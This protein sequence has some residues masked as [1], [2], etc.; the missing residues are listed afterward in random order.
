M[1]IAMPIAIDLLPTARALWRRK[2]GAALIAAQVALTLA[3]LCNALVVVLDRLGQTSRP[4]GVAED[5]LFYLQVVTPGYQDDPFGIQ[6][7]AEVLLRGLP[8]VNDA[9]WVNQVPL[10]NSGS[11]SGVSNE[12]LS[13]SGVNAAHYS[14]GRSL[15][16]AFGLKLVEGRDFLPDEFV[17]LDLRST[18]QPPPQVIVTRA[19]AQALYPGQ[20]S[21]V[22]RSVRLGT[23]TEDPLLTIVGVVER[24]VSPWGRASWMKGDTYG[25]RGF[26]TPARVNEGETYLV[27]ADPAGLDAI[28]QEA[29]RRLLDAVPGRILLSSRDQNTVRERRYRGDRW[30]AGMLGTVT[31][32]LLLMTA[33]GIVGLASLWVTQRRKQIGVRRALG[34]RRADIVGQFLVENLMINGAGVAL[35]LTLAVALNVGLARVTA[36]PPLPAGLMAAGALAL[37]VLGA[38]SVLAPAV[39]AS[40]ISPAEATRSA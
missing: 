29:E 7:A 3:I 4:L 9:A 21:V 15:V 34:A 8:G 27:R 32:L 38:L 20:A 30:L 5:A 35:G 25:E 39:R 10:S 24:L 13:I 23:T 28:R 17:A 14:A 16:Q 37:L 33:A 31:G 11:S 40:R 12:D 6:Q 36:L 19:A 1:R 18:R 2:G 26:I 22:G